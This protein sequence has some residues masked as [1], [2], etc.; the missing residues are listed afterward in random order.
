[1]LFRSIGVLIILTV[2]AARGA[3]PPDAKFTDVTAASGVN[4]VHV[5]GAYGDKLLPETMGGG[6]AFLDYDNDGAQDLLFVQSDHWNGHVP[7]GAKPQAAAMLYHNDGAGRFTDVTASSGFANIRGFYGMGVAV[8]D[9]DN[10]GF[11]D[12]LLTGVGGDRLFHNTG[13]GTFEDV[14]DS[15]GVAGAKD[16]WGTSAAFVDYDNDGRLDLFVCNYV[17]W[18]PQIDREVNYTLPKIGRAYGPPMNYQGQPCRLFHNEGA[19]KFSDVSKKSGIADSA[20]KSLGVAPVDLDGDG[21]IDFVVANDTTPNFVFHNQRD[22]SFKEIGAR[23]GIA[24]DSYGNTRG[25]MGIDAARWRNDPTLGI[26][27][28]NFANESAALYSCADDSMLF[29]DEAG[30]A[31]IADFTRPTLKFGLLF[32]DYDLDGFQ[33]LL[34]TNGHL[35]ERIAEAQPG[36]QYKQPAQLFWNGA[37]SGGGFIYVPPAKCGADLYKPIVGRGSA[38]ADIDDDGDLDL[39]QTQINAP[40]MLLRNDQKLSH[41]FIRLRLVGNGTT[42]NRDAIGAQVHVK[43]GGDDSHTIWRQVMPAKSYLSQSELPITIGLGDATKVASIEIT[44]PD[45]AKQTL[46]DAKV[47]GMTTVTQPHR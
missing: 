30:Q 14:T 43:L 36:Q 11:P 31:A 8:G 32:F 47:D 9:Y 5:N 39:V 20:G 22:G 34:L 15:A 46:T 17:K 18:S 25:A 12:V 2:V 19:G 33:D 10:D 37:K 24:F 38:S 44:W 26:A 29:T 23:T 45:G 16:D 40:V 3:E 41:H 35:D 27:V 28:A 13:H 21:Y 1:M 42:S 4:F 7:D 6:V